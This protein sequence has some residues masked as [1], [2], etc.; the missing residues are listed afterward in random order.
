MTLCIEIK[1]S[2]APFVITQKYDLALRN[3]VEQLR[4][5]TSNKKA[6]WAVFISPYG[7]GKSPYNHFFLK[8]LTMNIFFESL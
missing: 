1:Y 6:L 8:D 3:K 4:I 5:N 7:L 2:Q